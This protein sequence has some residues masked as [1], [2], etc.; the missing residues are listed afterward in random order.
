MGSQKT[1]ELSQLAR[2]I[3]ASDEAAF[4]KLF[5][6]LYPRMIKF[7]WRYTQTKSVAQD[8]VQESFIKL[9]N[10]RSNIDPAQSIL[11]YIYQIVRNNSLNHLRDNSTDDI[12]IGDLP[13]NALKSTEYVPEVTTAE[14]K[15]GKQMLKFIDRLPERQREAIRLSRFEGLDHEEIAYV[16]NISPRTVNNHIVAALKTLRTDWEMFKKEKKSENHYE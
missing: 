11:A 15:N 9:W 3:K 14:D 5:H 6:R 2:Q 1:K 16:M 10:K 13:K 12:A 8:I 4:S 7:C